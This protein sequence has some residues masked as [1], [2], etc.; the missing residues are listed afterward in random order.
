V[1]GMGADLFARFPALVAQ[2]DEILG[3]SLEELC[4]VDDGARLR[5]TSYCQPALFVVEALGFLAHAADAVGPPPD[6]FAGHSVGEYAALFAA[7]VLDFGTGLRLVRRRGELMA[8]CGPGSMAALLGLEL[9]EIEALLAAAGLTELDIALHNAP[10]QYAVAGPDHAIDELSDA[11]FDHGARCIRLNVSGPFH[12]RYMQPAADAF[13]DELSTASLRDPQ[14]QVI[15]N[16]TGLPVRS[17]AFA[18]DSLIEQLTSPVLWRESIEYLLGRGDL[19]F[20]EIGPGATL[21]GMVTRIRDG[22]EPER[23]PSRVPAKRAS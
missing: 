2:A 4:L 17:V 8:E 19:D 9:P 7:G 5:Q 1:C 13:S 11:A 20:V 10:G 22:F 14:V 21:T 15:T 23:P 16:A 18:V 3:Y 12:S 6:A